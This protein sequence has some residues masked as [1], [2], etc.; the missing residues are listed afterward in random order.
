MIQAPLFDPATVSDPNVTNSAFIAEYCC[1]LLKS[2]FPHLT[3]AQVTS[4]VQDL[5]QL[6]SDPTKFKVAVRDFL[7]QL[8]EFQGDNGEAAELF[9]DEKEAERQRKQEEDRERAQNVP[10]MLK[11][12]E[13]TADQDE[14][15]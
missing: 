11:P 9:A 2:A 8:R 14:E 1:G 6:N 7:I 4:F 3:N 13:M 10:G 15:L 12:S 5:R